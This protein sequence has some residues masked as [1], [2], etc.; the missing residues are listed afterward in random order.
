[1]GMSRQD[2][3]STEVEVSGPGRLGDNI[4]VSLVCDVPFCDERCVDDI[5]Q[6]L[7]GASAKVRH[8]VLGNPYSV[9]QELEIYG[10]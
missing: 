4:V 7:V 6:I 3:V 5:Q 1:M 10:E 2:G 8:R 9:E